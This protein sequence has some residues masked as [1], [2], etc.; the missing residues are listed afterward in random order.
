MVYAISYSEYNTRDPRARVTDI[1]FEAPVV[2]DGRGH[3]LG[4][5]GSVAAKE[6]IGGQKVIIVCC[7]QITISGSLVRN[8]R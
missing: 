5:L 8:K 7:E 2:I 6:L 4:R 3:L 1:M